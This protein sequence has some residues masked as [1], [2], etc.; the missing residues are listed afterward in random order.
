[1]TA[2]PPVT[3]AIPTIGRLDYLP[4][5]RASLERQR[6]ADVEALILDNESPPDA[7]DFFADW[8]RSDRRVRVVRVAPRI[9]MFANFDR[10][11]LL[12]AGKYLAFFHD[13]D[14]YAPEFLEKHVELLDREPGVGFAGCNNDFI[15]E[16]G[17]I[18]ERRRWIR[19]TRAIAGRAYIRRLFRTGRNVVPMQGIV[20][21]KAALR[22]EGFD[23]T[24]SCHFGDFV[25]LMRMAE[26]HDVGLV[27]DPVVRVRR[28]TRQTSA[29]MR[30]SEG[31][32][33][34]VELMQKYCSEYRTRWPDDATFLHSMQQDLA[35]SVRIGAV[36]GWLTAV[37]DAEATACR[38]AL[39]G[40]RLGRELS[41]AMRRAERL[42]LKS[43]V[44]RSL[45]APF[46][47]RLGNALGV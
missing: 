1:M 16:E 4:E 26:T 41:S 6:F 46:V 44:R 34:R 19:R 25:I 31:L 7:R 12:G 30:L 3:V 37:D 27:R 43:D 40:A 8:A 5:V 23:D 32:S 10:G 24:M 22:P 13:D 21:R 9:S 35:R 36:W 45:L 11:R 42:G 38:E 15:D 2:A 14:S 18:L 17:H 33:L 29:S 20:Y 28:H 47:R 39:H